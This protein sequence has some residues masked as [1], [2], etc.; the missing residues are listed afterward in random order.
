MPSRFIQF[1][2]SMTALS[3]V[4]VILWFIKTFQNRDRLSFY[5]RIDSAKEIKSG[6][7]ELL[8]NH[9]LLLIFL[10]LIICSYIL[11]KLATRKLPIVPIE[12]KSIKPADINFNT[13][14]LSIISPFA[15]LTLT[16]ISD[17]LFM[18]LFFS[19]CVIY[20]LII[21]G[22]YHYNFIMRLFL[23]YKYFEVQSK[24]EVTYL[25][26]SKK[27]LIN[28]SQIKNCVMLTPHMIINLV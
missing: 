12:V 3:P 20:A 22:S 4:L 25:A 23:G 28:S 10:L 16:G 27:R 14:L 26:L 13:L 21:N 17:T 1:F 15:K 2:F 24:R 11:I 8:R 19:I 5:V 7:W 9:Y 6:L 18:L